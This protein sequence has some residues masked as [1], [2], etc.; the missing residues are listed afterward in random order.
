MQQTNFFRRQ[1]EEAKRMQMDEQQRRRDEEARMFMQVNICPPV[2]IVW[3]QY[4]YNNLLKPA[5]LFLFF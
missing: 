1:Q 5:T 2:L 3:I 4:R